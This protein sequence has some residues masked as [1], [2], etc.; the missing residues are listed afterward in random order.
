MSLNTSFAAESTF[1]NKTFIKRMEEKE[2]M[3]DTYQVKPESW[4]ATK[5][6]FLFATGSERDY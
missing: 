1:T 5:N 3:T 4:V 2:M 6:F